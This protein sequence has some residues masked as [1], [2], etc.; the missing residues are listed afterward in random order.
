MLRSTRGRGTCQDTARAGW[1]DEHHDAITITKI[2]TK[3]I[4]TIKFDDE[5]ATGE[6]GGG[7]VIVMSEQ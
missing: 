5:E 1:V 4:S 3:M 6:A 7:V 2:K